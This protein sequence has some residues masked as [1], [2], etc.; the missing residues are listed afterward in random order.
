MK[1]VLPTFSQ[2]N[3]LHRYLVVCSTEG[4]GTGHPTPFNSRLSTPRSGGMGCA[5]CVFMCV[6]A[7][8]WMCG[9][10]HLVLALYEDPTSLRADNYTYVRTYMHTDQYS[11]DRK[12]LEK[13]NLWGFMNYIYHVSYSVCVKI[14]EIV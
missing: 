8:A 11:L 5:I 12:G 3:A 4:K 14:N 7:C 9:Y 1:F 10:A 2:V 13:I 6:P